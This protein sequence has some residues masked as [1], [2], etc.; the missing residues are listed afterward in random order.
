MVH[1]RTQVGDHIKE[2]RQKSKEIDEIIL[3]VNV[4]EKNL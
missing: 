3:G 2:I 1:E 4:V